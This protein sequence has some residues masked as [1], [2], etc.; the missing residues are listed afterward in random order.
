M[1]N[2]TILAGGWTPFVV[3]YLFNSCTN[4]LTVLNQS[5]TGGNTSWISLHPTNK[6][7]LYAINEVS[8][9]GAL[10]SYTIDQ[11]G[12]LSGAI[13][14][15]STEGDRAA[16]TT[17]LSTGQVAVVNYLGGNALVVPTKPEEPLE[18]LSSFTPVP[19]DA[20]I[21]RPHMVLEHGNELFIPDIGAN[22]VW[23]LVEDGA[24]GAFKVQ[25]QIDEPAGYGPRHIA[26]RENM[27]YTLH[28]Q[29]SALTQQ[30]IPRPPN[31]TTGPLIANFNVTPPGLPEGAL[32]GAS[33]IVLAEA[34]P[35]FPE[36]FI[37]VS[38]RNVGS[39]LDPRGDAIA[40]FRVEPQLELVGYA[41]TGLLQ[42]RSMALGGPE[43][44]FLVAAGEAGSGGTIVMR[45][46]EGGRNL[47]IVARNTDV[48]TRT[49]FVWLD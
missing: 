49:T 42:V 33:E 26:I 45:R 25:G 16:F 8:P 39:A 20:P 44:E 22:K 30:E 34:S 9:V 31:G 14:T 21:S 24:P 13:D 15:I 48:P 7:I 23:R 47:T 29:R 46:T 32:L 35:T 17:A 2:F 28:E 18:F 5:P 41:F 19:F 38:N 12:A 3:S 10:Q 1:V 36:P 27:L 6:S 43:N 37:Y 40:I 11:D 4:S